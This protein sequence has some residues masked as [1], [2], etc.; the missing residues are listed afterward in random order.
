MITLQSSRLR[1]GIALPGEAP[2]TTYRFDRAGF[3]S[4]VVLDGKHEFCTREP[5]NLSHPCT[6]GV[7]LCNEFQFDRASTEAAAGEYFP[8]FGLG[9]CKSD[10]GE[11]YCFS[12]QYEL[13]PYPVTWEEQTD[14]VVFHTAPISC[15]GYEM[16]HDKTLSVE[17]NRLKM[18]VSVEN[19]GD[20][21]VDMQEYCHNFLTLDRLPLGPD[22]L[23]ELPGITTRGNGVLSG[24][25]Q[26]A[27][28]GYTFSDYNPS[29][30]MVN[31]EEAEIADAVPFVWRM[32]NRRTP[33]SVTVR[34]DF[35]PYRLAMWTID[36]IISVEV[37]HRTVLAPGQKDEWTRTWT[38]END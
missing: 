28:S 3:I 25:I 35:R 21:P 16:K 27:G 22:Y 32:S 30:A 19:T 34:E 29:A 24:T 12:K 7:G 26:G 5:D 15:L 33:L 13:K 4:S 20:K 38:F 37:F 31:V 10:D 17:D 9:L 36:H 8:K 14:S 2:N 1:I 18:T 23:I 11:P 6:G